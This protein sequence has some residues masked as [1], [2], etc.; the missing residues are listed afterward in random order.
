MIAKYYRIPSHDDVAEDWLLTPWGTSRVK[1]APSAPH[2]ACWDFLQASSHEARLWAPRL[3]AGGTPDKGHRPC[4]QTP[5]VPPTHTEPHSCQML[6]LC[7]ESI[8]L[9]L[10]LCIAAASVCNALCSAELSHPLWKQ[11]VSP[12]WKP[13]LSCCGNTPTCLPVGC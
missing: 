11:L 6:C 3:T 13:A 8:P 10:G 5:L 1:A 4:F 9:S 7:L 2:P 12:A